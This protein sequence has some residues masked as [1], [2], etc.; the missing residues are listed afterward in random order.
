MTITAKKISPD[1][2]VVDVSLDDDPTDIDLIKALGGK[3]QS[4]IVTIGWIHSWEFLK[5]AEC[6]DLLIVGAPPYVGS[7]PQRQTCDLNDQ[8]ARAAI[9]ALASLGSMPSS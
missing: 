1:G 4:D 9:R 2:S 5:I 8:Q 7:N 6:D 3:R